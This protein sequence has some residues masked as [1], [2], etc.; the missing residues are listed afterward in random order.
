VKHAR[1]ADRDEWFG[2]FRNEIKARVERNCSRPAE[3]R[4]N[5]SRLPIVYTRSVENIYIRPSFDNYVR[6]FG[7]RFVDAR[8]RSP[9]AQKRI[10]RSLPLDV[11]FIRREL[12]ASTPL[13]VLLYDT[14]T[15]FIPSTMDVTV[16]DRNETHARTHVGRIS[17]ATGGCDRL[18][19]SVPGRP[20]V[21]PKVTRAGND[22]Q[23]RR[24][25]G[26]KKPY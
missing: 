17:S 9:V 1:R 8:Y 5:E 2:N 6:P 25:T 12:T 21:L 20:N 11:L 19:K 14:C 10:S 4:R 15:T 22:S 18:T 24:T 3:F 23:P 16:F 26:E 13:R 7:V